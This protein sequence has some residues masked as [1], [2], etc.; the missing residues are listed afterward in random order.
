MPVS[1]HFR[2]CKALLSRIVSGAISSELYLLPFLPLCS[3]YSCESASIRLRDAVWLP[4]DAIRRPIRLSFEVES[5]SSGNRTASNRS[6]TF[7]HSNQEVE[8]SKDGSIPTQLDSLDCIDTNF[9][10]TF[11][12]LQ[13]DRATGTYEKYSFSSS[14]SSHR[15]EVKFSAALRLKA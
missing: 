15:T 2:G 10:L 7:P 14:G 8:I 4:F 11:I 9:D 6:L 3:D 13:F 5:P 1:C 12:R